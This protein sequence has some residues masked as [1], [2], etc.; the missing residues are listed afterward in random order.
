MYVCTCNNLNERKI[1]EAAQGGCSST[2]ELSR[3]LGFSFQCRK[4]E[5]TME[6]MVS[7]KHK[8]EGCCKSETA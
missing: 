6:A 2:E 1:E 7:S 4:C 5:K 8:E 3:S